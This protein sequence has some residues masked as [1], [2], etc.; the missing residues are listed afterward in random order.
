[1]HQSVF[2]DHHHT[3]IIAHRGNSSQFPENSYLA[4]W[5]AIQIGVDFLEC[6]VQLSKDAVP[7]VI[8]DSTFHRI[9]KN[10]SSHSVNELDLEQIKTIDAGS[11]FDP[12]FSDQ[13]ILTLKEF[14]AM[15]KGKTGMMLDLKAETISECGLAK[16]VGD[17]IV[18]CAHL[19]PHIGP[20]LVGSLNPNTLLCLE[21]Y[22]PEQL[23]IPIVESFENWKDFRAFRAANY[24]ISEALITKEII[25]E[26]NG[27]GRKV[28]AWTVDDKNSAV[29]LIEMGVRGLITNHPKKMMALH[30]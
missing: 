1:M 25:E 16:I 4:F 20:I 19:Y 23:F 7:V 24:A 10:L 2:K 21:A 8:H 17:T 13:R 14:F 22:L 15:P 11:W 27:E 26:L 12:R 28:W 6:D 9:T 18:S 5:E 29:R 3:L 30:G